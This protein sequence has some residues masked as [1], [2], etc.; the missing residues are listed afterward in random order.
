MNIA[1]RVDASA[2]VGTGHIMRCLTLA[3]ALN[4]RK[5]AVR[6]LSRHMP[7][8]FRDF[9]SGRGYEFVDLG[10]AFV[11]LPDEPRD[12]LWLDAT[13]S[14]DAAAAVHALSDR[15][16]DWLIV[17]NYALDIR[18]ESA[19]RRSARRIASIDDIANRQHDCDVLLDP[20]FYSDM[21]S[22]Y[23]GSVPPHCRMLLGPRFALLR[24]EFGQFHDHVRPRTGSVKRILVFFGGV[25]T[26]NYTGAAIQALAELGIPDVQ[27]DVVIG[28][29]HPAREGIES[30]CLRLGFSLHVQ[31]GRMAE[32]MA[33]ADLA[34]G[35]GGG[36][37]WERC[38][39][40]LPT[41]AICVAENQRRQIADAACAGLL[42]A[43]DLQ[44]DSSRFVARH[45]RALI[46]NSALRHAMSRNGM[47]V[48]DGCGASRVVSSIECSG[49]RLRE[50]AI[51]DSRKIFEWRNHPDIRAASRV[52]DVISWESH[53]NWF[54]AVRASPDR[55]LLI[56][57][58][59]GSAVGV[60]R[61]DL[62]GDEAEISIY[63][64]PGIHPRGTGRELLLAAEAW[65]AENRPDVA[66][67]RAQVLGANRRSQ[68]LFLGADY[69]V[70]STCYL[71]RH[72]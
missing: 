40:G 51:E 5:V 50:A 24:P 32:L 38:C 49:I 22:R 13:Q 55:L 62:I 59:L 27:I 2:Q 67:I 47:Q 9:L 8:H 72:H 61:F 14:A 18:W 43:P 45:V 29:M 20:N 65:L 36:A 52:G 34:I 3:D 4:E 54:A 31:S 64:V 39:V 53:E 48:V 12:A 71:K 7:Q 21:A 16:W 25:D 70:D 30:E 11:G 69:R 46:E 42:Y 17:D 60:V 37:A 33:A 23:I 28:E 68:R 41:L 35:A 1:F 26:R 66:Q 56:G 15:I 44:E 19:L 10:A 57:E 63:L 58:R 6:F